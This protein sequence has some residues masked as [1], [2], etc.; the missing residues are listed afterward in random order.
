VT[1]RG[2]II[3]QVGTDLAGVTSIR[4]YYSIRPFRVDPDDKNT[5][6]R[7]SEPFHDLLV[8]DLA[9]FMLR[10]AATVP[11]AVRGVAMGALDAEETEALANFAAAVKE[12]T[13]AAEKG[14]FGRTAGATKQ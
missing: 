12:F 1:L 6:I 13:S 10:K 14:R 9:K 2:G 3:R 5:V 11:E 4:V 8:I 7:L